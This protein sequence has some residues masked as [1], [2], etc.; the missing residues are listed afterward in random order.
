MRL[1]ARIVRRTSTALVG[2]TTQYQL[3]S[4][5]GIGDEHDV[6]VTFDGGTTPGGAD[7]GDI[8]EEATF[9]VPSSNVVITPAAAAPGET[10]SLEITGMPIYEQVD[11]VMIDGGNRL[12]GTAINT[13]SEGN[14]TIEGS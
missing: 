1:T 6:V 2:S 4:G 10:I 9:A 13:D 7:R 8:E 5:I 3:S 14:V 11:S 12:S